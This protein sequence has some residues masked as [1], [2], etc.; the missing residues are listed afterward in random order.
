MAR[1][2]NGIEKLDQKMRS[3]VRIPYLINNSGDDRVEVGRKNELN[4]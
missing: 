1:V 2:Y 4:Q 3:E